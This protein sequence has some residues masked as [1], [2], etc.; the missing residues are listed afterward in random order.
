MNKRS[1]LGVTL[2]G[3][4]LVLLLGQL[5]GWET[6]FS[7]LVVPSTLAAYKFTEELSAT[8]VLGFYPSLILLAIGVFANLERLLRGNLSGG[9]FFSP[10][11]AFWLVYII[12]TR[13][14][15][16]G[17]CQ[18]LAPISSHWLWQVS[19]NRV[20][21]VEQVETWRRAGV[22]N[23]LFLSLDCPGALPGVEAARPARLAAKLS[24][25]VP[26]PAIQAFRFLV[27]RPLK[28]SQ[29]RDGIATVCHCLSGHDIHSWDIHHHS[30]P[31]LDRD[32]T[33]SA[34]DTG[35]PANSGNHPSNNPLQ[36]ST[37]LPSLS[38]LPSKLIA[39]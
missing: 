21:L 5:N 28:T 2:I 27:S 16:R 12:H 6:R 26:N 24:C 20:T 14:A 34:R 30:S 18:T 31:S 3:V 7:L 32:S 38:H 36:D 13:H 39:I 11:R 35:V 8:A 37:V 22:A 10:G 15:R 25:R 29:N 23:Y 4:G 17:C 1:R 19:R 9:W 33:S